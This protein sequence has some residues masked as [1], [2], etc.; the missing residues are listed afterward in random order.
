VH[1][2]SFSS[3][4][5]SDTE[6]NNQILERVRKEECKMSTYRENENQRIREIADCMAEAWRDKI[7][8]DDG[9]NSRNAEGRDDAVESHDSEEG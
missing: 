1:I 2:A 6:P 3:I 9:P 8:R 5:F 7:A 4:L